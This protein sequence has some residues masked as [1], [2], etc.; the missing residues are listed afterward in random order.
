MAL[1]YTIHVGA[2]RAFLRNFE[3]VKKL[4]KKPTTK[5]LFIYYLSTDRSQVGNCGFR[6][7]CQMGL[8]IS[9]L[10]PGP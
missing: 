5:G 4:R 1:E 7:D 8:L 10:R 9:K 6:S 2:G 3:Q